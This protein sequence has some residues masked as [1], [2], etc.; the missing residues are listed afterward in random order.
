MRMNVV[1]VCHSVRMRM[2]YGT[3]PMFT[4]LGLSHTQETPKQ[5]TLTLR[6]F[7]HKPGQETVTEN[8]NIVLRNQ[9]A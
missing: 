5:L 7:G 6:V 3:R 4:V 9:T 8:V 2:L 1:I